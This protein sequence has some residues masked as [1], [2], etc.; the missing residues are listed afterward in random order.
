MICFH[1]TIS[2]QRQGRGPKP[3]STIRSSSSTAALRRCGYWSSASPP[4][5][6]TGQASGGGR[7]ARA[8]PS[9]W[10]LGSS[11]APPV[12]PAGGSAMDSIPLERRLPFGDESRIGA[13]EILALHADRLRLRLGLDRLL[14]AN[15]PFGVKLPLGH[16]MG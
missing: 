7:C 10:A 1:S 11:M 2:R 13:T 12:L 14:D 3:F 9:I 8:K 5:S 16:G 6:K 4:V 15:R